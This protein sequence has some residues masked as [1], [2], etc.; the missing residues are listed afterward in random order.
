MEIQLFLM[1]AV[2]L[3]LIKMGADRGPELIPIQERNRG[4]R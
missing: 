1:A 2:S 3:W 4:R